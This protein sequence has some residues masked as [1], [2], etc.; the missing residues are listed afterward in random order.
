MK[1]SFS[2]ESM[3]AIDLLLFHDLEQV[4][5]C[6]Q[7]LHPGTID[8]NR[9]QQ[10]LLFHSLA[11]KPLSTYKRHLHLITKNEDLSHSTLQSHQYILNFPKYI[12]IDNLCK[13]DSHHQK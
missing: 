10:T 4:H 1:Y 9:G 7:W 8:A 2:L 12:P 13:M 11:L 6:R 3:I 5:R